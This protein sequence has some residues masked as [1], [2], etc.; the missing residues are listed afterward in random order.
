MSEERRHYAKLK[1]A[2]ETLD[3]LEARICSEHCDSRHAGNGVRWNMDLGG[4]YCVDCNDEGYY[5]NLYLVDH[6][7]VG[8]ALHVIDGLEPEEDFYD[9]AF[10]PEE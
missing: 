4:I 10:L 3:V 2:T 9:V 6:P 1:P 8:D 5:F 7:L